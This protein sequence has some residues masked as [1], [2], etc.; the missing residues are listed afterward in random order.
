VSHGRGVGIQGG[1]NPL[2]VVA[3]AIL[4]NACRNVR[5]PGDGAIQCRHDAVR[6]V[7]TRSSHADA[8]G[9]GSTW[10][11]HWECT[12][13]IGFSLRSILGI[14]TLASRT[15]QLLGGAQCS[16]S[17]GE[18]RLGQCDGERGRSDSNRGLHAACP[19]LFGNLDMSGYREGKLGKIGLKFWQG[20]QFA[21]P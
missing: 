16:V 7:D 13:Q 15:N 8:I 6:H 11:L 4:D 9:K 5:S 18:F 19:Q 10:T 14:E 20:L 21:R 2:S 3:K 17:S 12:T 1:E